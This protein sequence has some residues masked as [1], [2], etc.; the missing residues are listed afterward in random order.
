MRF[1][2]TT[3]SRV[4]VKT[5]R[6]RPLR[7]RHHHEVAKLCGQRAELPRSHQRHD[8]EARVL[9]E[10]RLDPPL[11]ARRLPIQHRDL[12]AFDVERAR[13]AGVFYLCGDPAP[14][15]GVVD[16]DRYEHGR[17]S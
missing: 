5:R 15:I 14:K 16:E 1:T 9:R 7:S 13:I 8:I 11:E 4:E 12:R 3:I 17:P 10:A 2:E 6:E